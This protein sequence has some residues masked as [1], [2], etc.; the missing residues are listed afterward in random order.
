MQPRGGSRLLRR[1]ID[2][3]DVMVVKACPIVERGFFNFSAADLWHGAVVDPV[4]GSDQPSGG[5]RRDLAG[6][7]GNSGTAHGRPIR[8]GGKQYIPHL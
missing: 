5:V 8:L 2:P 1:F 6:G 3:V 7:S 4:T